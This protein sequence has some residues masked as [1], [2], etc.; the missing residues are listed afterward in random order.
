[1]S[2]K[3]K[4]PTMKKVNEASKL[5]ANTLNSRPLTPVVQTILDS[6]NVANKTKFVAA[7][8]VFFDIDGFNYEDENSNYDLVPTTLYNGISED[9]IVDLI[10]VTNPEVK[11]TLET[12]V[13]SSYQ[14]L[15]HMYKFGKKHKQFAGLVGIKLHDMENALVEVGAHYVAY[16]YDNGNFSFFDSGMAGSCK[17]QSE[18]NNTFIILK[19]A[20]GNIAKANKV[21]FTSKCNL[22]TFETEAGVTEDE[23]NYVG[24][25]IFCH[26][27]CLWFL[28]QRMV[29][30][31]SMNAIDNMAV[32]SSQHELDKQ[33]LI[34]IKSFIISYILPTAGIS[35]LYK[36]KEFHPFFYYI[37][38]PPKV[39]G[40]KTRRT[41]EVMPGF[42]FIQNFCN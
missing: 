16:I 33:N 25:N 35:E 29:L 12:N 32:A 19:T 14:T 6:A 11:N 10:N 7:P 13:A 24:Q 5:Y 37:V 39:N 9:T 4:G 2:V 15:L 17:S 31:N 18:L 30:N 36:N 34:R 22:G 41:T 26:S 42:E 38:N 23:Y 3:V 8:Y 40:G 27:W 20:L 1:M 28:Y 21:R